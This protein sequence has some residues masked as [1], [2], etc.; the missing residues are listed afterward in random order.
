M[1]GF[2]FSGIY[3]LSIKM[4][5]SPIVNYISEIFHDAE[6]PES[7]GCALCCGNELAGLRSV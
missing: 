3:P 6:G 7:I 1:P 5:V 4:L 2:Y